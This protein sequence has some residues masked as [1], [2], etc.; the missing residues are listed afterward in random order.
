MC[1]TD[2]RRAK[3]RVRYAERRIDYLREVVKALDSQGLPTTQS[4]IMLD[5][6]ERA[7]DQRRGDLA[8][9][10]REKE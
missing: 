4:L 5:G 1:A 6:M 3:R 10:L 2:L 8:S 9:I 7:L